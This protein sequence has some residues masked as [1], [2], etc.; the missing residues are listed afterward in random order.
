M[1]VLVAIPCMDMVHTAFCRSL[2]GMRPVGDYLEYRFS[3][4]SLIY[5]SRNQ[6]A[7]YAIT[8][9]FD[10]VLWVD[11]DMVFEPDALQR[12]NADIDCGIDY[13]SGLFTGRKPP[14]KPCI[15]KHITPSGRHGLP[16]ALPMT[17]YDKNGLTKVAGSGLAFVL[18]NTSLIEAVYKRYGYMFSPIIGM[19][20]DLSFCYRAASLGCEMYCDSRVKIGHVGQIIYNESFISEDQK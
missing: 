20:E 15:Y 18:M 6:L 14:V 13:V 5:D 16:E 4:N 9:K 12:L 3:Q 2:V 7:E 19:G 10:R 11:S 8:Y 1:K 17:D